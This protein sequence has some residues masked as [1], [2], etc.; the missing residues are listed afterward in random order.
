MRKLMTLMAFVALIAAATQARTRTTQSGLRDDGT[1][2]ENIADVEIDSTLALDPHAVTLRGFAKRASDTKETFFVTN[3]TEHAISHVCLL[4]R[5]RTL[6]DEMLHERTVTVTVGAAPG[7]TRMVSVP[8]FDK[9]RLFYYY[10]GPR[11]RKSAT[12]FKVGF[13]LLGYDIPVGQITP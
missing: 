10:N 7:E 5:Y 13:K 8:S 1:P 9:Q 4:L 11:P 6:D 3:N 12:P 2:V